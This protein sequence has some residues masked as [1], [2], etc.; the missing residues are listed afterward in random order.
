MF[1]TKSQKTN[2]EVFIGSARARTCFSSN[3]GRPGVWGFI[4][5]YFASISGEE[6]TVLASQ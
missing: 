6:Q 2:N 5:H 3:Q 1:L 4:G